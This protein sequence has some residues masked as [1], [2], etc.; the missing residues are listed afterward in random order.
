[1]NDFMELD[2]KVEE[3]WKKVSSENI[4]VD[5]DTIGQAQ[6]QSAIKQFSRFK[7][8]QQ[9]FNFLMSERVEQLERKS[10]TSAKK[11]T[12]PGVNLPL[13]YDKLCKAIGDLYGFDDIRE[14]FQYSTLVLKE[15]DS[16]F[17][18]YSS[19]EDKYRKQLILKLRSALKL[20]SSKKIFTKEQ[21]GILNSVVERLRNRTVDKGDVLE[22][23]DDLENSDLSPFPQLE[24]G[25]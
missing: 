2:L 5:V 11:E 16:I 4:F 22:I 20:N 19:E 13:H 18:L 6:W 8:D 3:R 9:E 12:N 25:E 23:L 24:D 15:I 7:K 1:M 10:I 14:Q 17:E 21:I